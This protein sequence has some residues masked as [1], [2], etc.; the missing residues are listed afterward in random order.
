MEKTNLEISFWQTGKP[1]ATHLLHAAVRLALVG[2]LAHGPG[3][4]HRGRA[5]RAPDL[6][7]QLALVRPPLGAAG[8]FPVV[9]RFGAL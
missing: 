4:G 7:A 2:E 1:V 3:R 6:G 5:R 9:G 8:R